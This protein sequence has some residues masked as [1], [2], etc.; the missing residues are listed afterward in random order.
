MGLPKPRHY[1]ER[2]LNLTR[3]AFSDGYRKILFFL[4]TGGGKSI[5]FLH[6]IFN[7][8]GNNKKICLVMRR[9]QLVFQAANHFKKHGLNP[10]VCMGSIKG[11]DKNNPFQ[12][13]SIDT[14]SRRNTDFL[15]EF[16]FVI[17]DEAHDTTSPTYRK[18]F[19]IFKKAAFIGLTATPFQ[20][21]KKVQDF[22]QACVKPIEIDQL[23][24]EGFLTD[25]NIYV[26]NEL[27]LS[28]IKIDSAS[29]DY[30]T[31]PLSEKMRDLSIIGDVVDSYKK[32]GNN[33]PAILFAVDKQHSMSLAIEFNRQGIPAIH[34]D[35][36]TKQKE[37]D[38]AIQGLI[39]GKYKILCNVNI[40]STGVD[41]PQAIVGIMARPTMSE[42]LY[43]QQ[44]GRLL[45]PYRLCGK[46]NTAYDNSDNCP[47][48][49]YS[50]PSFIK[51]FA[52]I[53]DNA[54][55]IY[56]HGHPFKKRNAILSKKELKKKKEEEIDE[57]KIKNCKHCF[58]A[59]L[60]NLKSCP[61]CDYKN[62]KVEREIKRADGKIVPYDEFALMRHKFL[63]FEKIKL[64]R[65]LKPH[66]SNFQMYKEF[67]DR[68][69]LY[70]DLKI[71]SWIKKIADKGTKEEGVYK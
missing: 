45:R 37:R 40:F 5:I 47:V 67:G 51:E 14:I 44:V 65:N 36:S 58:A 18:F 48:C 68:V 41:I 11:F 60:A 8:L 12:I 7:L 69:Y 15:Q 35:E 20:V 24:K 61:E 9:R 10:S 1:Q 19:E 56:R 29:G 39:E 21:G 62:E 22:W 52:I 66:F 25:A 3:K 43:I 53:I 6:L 4:A 59:Y 13:C 71:P 38:E 42:I 63:E 33:W 28:D 46:C 23:V 54:N 50:K 64:E 34:C 55:N 16:D 30:K 57:F 49:N 31:V 27:D 70:P 2:G 17:V 26:P 32:F